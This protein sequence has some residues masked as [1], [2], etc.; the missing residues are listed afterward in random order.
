MEPVYLNFF[1]INYLSVILANNTFE[2]LKKVLKL[3]DKEFKYYDLAG[4]ADPRYGKLN[5]ITL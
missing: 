5:P 4:L 1:L 3:G 2:H